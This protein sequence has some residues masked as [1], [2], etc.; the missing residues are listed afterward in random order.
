M[1]EVQVGTPAGVVS[2]AVPAP[3]LGARTIG[4]LSMSV[5]SPVLDGAAGAAIGWLVAPPSKKVGYAVGGGLA[6]GFFGLLGLGGTLIWRAF[7]KSS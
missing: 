1:A 2:P 6:A 4:T 5:G 3:T 7:D